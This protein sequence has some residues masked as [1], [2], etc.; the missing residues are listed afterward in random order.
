[1]NIIDS[2]ATTL[3]ILLYNLCSHPK[4]MDRLRHEIRKANIS[5][6]LDYLELNKLDYL[7]AIIRE[8]MYTTLVPNRYH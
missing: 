5:P 4:T 3:K 6:P 1:M 7:D 2:T 8:S